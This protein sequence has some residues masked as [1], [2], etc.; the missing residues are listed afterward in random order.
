MQDSPRLIY[1]VATGK[2]LLQVQDAFWTFR[3]TSDALTISSY[4]QVNV[5]DKSS[6]DYLVISSGYASI[7]EDLDFECHVSLNP[8]LDAQQPYSIMIYP[9]KVDFGIVDCH[10]GFHADLWVETESAIIVEDIQTLGL[11]FFLPVIK[12]HDEKTLEF[13][14][15]DKKITE[16]TLGRGDPREVWIDVP[17]KKSGPKELVIKCAYKEPNATD[18][19]NLGMIFVEYNVNLTEWKPA[20][21]LL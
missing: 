13:F 17:R 15:E 21:G 14:I 5:V 16:L 12:D 8:I 4:L 6:S 1:N 9:Q 3:S 20:G 11:K 18:E 10:R 2:W 19:R 7:V